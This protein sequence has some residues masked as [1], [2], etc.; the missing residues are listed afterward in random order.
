MEK[1]DFCLKNKLLKKINKRYKKYYILKK[2]KKEEKNESIIN[3]YCC[4]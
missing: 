2:T 4:L 1:L 3:W